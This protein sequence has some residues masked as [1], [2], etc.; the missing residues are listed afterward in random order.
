ME[1]RAQSQR[2]E[3]L[4]NWRTAMDGHNLFTKTDRE[5]GVRGKLPFP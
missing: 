5:D 2:W 1:L 4:N 3:S